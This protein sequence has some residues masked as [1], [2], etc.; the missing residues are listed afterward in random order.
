M[1]NLSEQLYVAGDFSSV[2]MVGPNNGPEIVE[3]VKNLETQLEQKTQ[4]L[5]TANQRIDELMKHIRNLNDLLH[6]HQ[7]P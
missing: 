7:N 2:K 1:K 3:A 6:N 4:A 5:H